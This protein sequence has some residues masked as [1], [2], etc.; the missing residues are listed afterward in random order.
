MPAA[1]Q[2][3]GRDPLVRVGR[4]GHVAH[5]RRQVEVQRAFV[6]A[7][8]K[9]I[10]PQ[11]GGLRIVLDQ[12]DLVVAAAGQA[13]VVQGHVVDEEHRRG[14][15]I[16]RRHVGD[17]GAV[18]QG[19]R[20]SAFAT[21]FE[22]GA[23]H[24]RCAQEFG[25]RQHHVGGGDAGLRLAAEFHADDVRQAHPRR[26]PEHHAFR[27]QSADANRNDAQR[28]H[29][30]RVAVG[31][32]AGVRVGHAIGH[33]DHRAHSLQVDLVHDPVARRDHVDVLERELGPVDEVEAVGV[34][35][36]L[37]RPVLQERV[38][39]EAGRFHRQR[40]VHDQLHRH[41]RIDLCRVAALLGDRIAQA[42]QVDQ[43]GL[44]EDVVADHARREPREV[45]VAAAL[46][47]LGQVGIQHV[48]LGAPHQVFR[49][50][51]RRVRQA[52]PGAGR[53]RLDRFARI[54]I[55]QVAVGQGLAE[56]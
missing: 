9:R 54:E 56:S 43:C 17:R 5:H 20:G 23:D 6:F 52:V 46:D 1:G 28:I 34:A 49:I 12:R 39:V 29:V 16:F 50:H 44:A 33:A 18:A 2:R 11:A 55:R 31:A 47:Q 51:P 13:Q 24:F 45:E 8:R 38:A 26:A 32:D 37:D 21:E 41:H 42:G 19:Q 40:V 14:R 25:Q 4:P 22:I 27:F 10:G 3:A 7:H 35:A 30:R 15:A 48:G 36:V 53:K